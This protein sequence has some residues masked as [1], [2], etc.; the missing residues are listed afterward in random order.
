MAGSATKE[1]EVAIRFGYQAAL[2]SMVAVSDSSEENIINHCRRIADL[3]PIVG[4]Y[5]QPAVGGRVFSYEF[6]RRFA[7]IPNLVAIKMA[8]PEP[9]MNRR[10]SRL[11]V[12]FMGLC[13]TC[14]SV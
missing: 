12:S 9:A 10:R 1:A 3:L 2:L 4:F 6:W 7:E 13:L 14:Q 11:N 8:P 5:L